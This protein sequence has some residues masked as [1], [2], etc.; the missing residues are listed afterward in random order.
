MT[1]EVCV[2]VCSPT[3]PRDATEPLPPPWI[4]SCF[5]HVSLCSAGHSIISHW[6]CLSVHS[7]VPV[8]AVVECLLSF[9]CVVPVCDYQSTSGCSNHQIVIKCLLC[10]CYTQL[11]REI[12]NDLSRLVSPFRP[13]DSAQQS[14]VTGSLSQTVHPLVA[15]DVCDRPIVGVRYKCGYLVVVVVVV[16]KFQLNAWNQT[17][18]P[19][20]FT[21]LITRLCQWT[22]VA[23]SSLFICLSVCLQHNSKTNDPRVFKLGVGNDLGIHNITSFRTTI[24]LYSR[25][26]GG[27]TSTITLPLW[28]IVIHYSLGGDTDKTNMAWVHTL[29]VHS[30]Y[31]D[32]DDDDDN[33]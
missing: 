24:A 32:D 26:L 25:S 16:N 31:N 30:S 23:C 3:K 2:C 11:Q 12:V 7:T 4:Q 14:D 13:A 8:C 5:Q 33:V 21:L 1:C 22:W 9:Y 10:L 17:Q 18:V 29:W 15:C 19:C 27:D 28:F 6:C 20:L